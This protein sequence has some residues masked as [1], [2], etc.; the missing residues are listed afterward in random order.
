MLD[1]STYIIITFVLLYVIL[2]LVLTRLIG[3]GAICKG[4]DPQEVSFT[5][6]DGPDPVYTPL[7]LDLMSKHRVKATFFVLGEKAEQHPELILRMQ[8]DG[9]LIGIHNYTHKMNI[10]TPPWVV[11]R[12][13]ERSANAIE[14]IT[15]ER[16]HYY[17]PPWGILS[18][19]DL[20]LAKHYKFALWSVMGFD[21]RRNSAE[22]NLKD[23]LL[24]Q[25]TS[26]SAGSVVLLH[27]CGN[28]WGADPDAPKYMLLALESVLNELKNS[29]LHY[30]RLDEMTLTLSEVHVVHDDHEVSAFPDSR[31]EHKS[32]LLN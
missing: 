18:L 24:R 7:L 9:H 11:R 19:A 1:L 22:N 30:V 25:I 8:Q 13:L 17:R 31:N 2:P 26:A 6:D 15:G 12:E 23:T 4:A 10:L 28:T 3:V 20:L 14:A 32:P 29:K 16:P 21:W 27:D 5:F